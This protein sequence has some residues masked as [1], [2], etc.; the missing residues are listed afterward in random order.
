MQSETPASF[1]MLLKAYRVAAGLSQGALAAKSGVSLRG[2]SD[3]ER[4]AR[5]RPRLDTARMLADALALSG[6]ERA[7]LF[8]AAGGHVARQAQADRLIV[9]AGAELPAEDSASHASTPHN[10]PAQMN[11]L[12]GRELELTAVDALLRRED[13]RLVTLTGPGGIGKTRLSVQVA[14]AL[15]EIVPRWRVAGAALAADRSD[16]G[17]H[18]DRARLGTE[19]AGCGPHRRD[20]P[21]HSARETPAVGPR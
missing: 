19:R 10:L 12:L 14:G 18:G 11:S 15:V 7:A 17:P 5:E 9:I 21:T 16:A 6:A 2:L 3:L 13:V 8:A 1:A 20:A 4:G